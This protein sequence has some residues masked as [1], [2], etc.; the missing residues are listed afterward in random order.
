MKNLLIRFNE[1]IPAGQ[2]DDITLSAN[3]FSS[4]DTNVMFKFKK[5]TCCFKNG[6]EM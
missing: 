5:K 1:K 3:I 2:S 6:M 4:V